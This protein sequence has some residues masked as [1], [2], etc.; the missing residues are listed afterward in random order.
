MTNRVF[1]PAGRGRSSPVGGGAGDEPGA[2]HPSA[3]LLEHLWRHEHGPGFVTA[4]VIDPFG[5]VLS[6]M[7]NTHHLEMLDH[8]AAPQ[9]AGR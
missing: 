8:D 1:R 5:T 3:E 6:V 2:A 4:S 7:T 9:P